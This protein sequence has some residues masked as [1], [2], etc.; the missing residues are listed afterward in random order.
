MEAKTL[1]RVLCASLSVTTDDRIT[2]S[3]TLVN[4]GGSF[5][6]VT[7]AHVV[8]REDGL[9]SRMEENVG[10][11]YSCDYAEGATA[12]DIVYVD[13]ESDLAFLVPVSLPRYMAYDAVRVSKH[14]ASVG[15]FVV[16]VGTPVDF[17]V[18]RQNLTFGVVSNVEDCRQG[19]CYRHDAA[20]YFGNSGGGLFNLSGEMV[21]VNVA[22]AV[23]PFGA[24]VP[25]SSVAVSRQTL[26]EHLHL[27]N[28]SCS[29]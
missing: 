25:G 26:L 2:G 24:V 8:L 28:K 18:H 12:A 14:N 23:T 13:A 11:V 27:A 6:A 9:Q 20:I 3:A 17:A 10:L 19:L 22:T 21:G 4:Y 16:A 7:A 29:E 15:D 5:L 1:D